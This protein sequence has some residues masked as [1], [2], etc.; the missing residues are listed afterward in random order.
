MATTMRVA[1]QIT[2]P[3]PEWTRRTG[4][5]VVGGGAAGL[6]VSARLLASGVP[7]VLISRERLITSATAWAT[8]PFDEWR[9]PPDVEAFVREGAGLADQTAAKDFLNA[10]PRV[11]DQF[12]RIAAAM[13]ST[14]DPRQAAGMT[15]YRTL[16]SL[17]RSEAAEP[18]GTLGIDTD[19]RAVDV[20]TD[21]SGHVAGLRVLGRDGV[22]GDYLAP[23]VVLASGGAGQLWTDTTTP[24]AATGDGLAMALRAGATLRD[25]EFVF[26]TPTALAVSGRMALP[27]EPLVELGSTLWRNG[28]DLVDGDQQPIWSESL[29]PHSPCELAV[30]VADARAA[31]HRDIYLD[32]RILGEDAWDSDD[33]LSTAR[34]CREHG[35]DPAH[36]PVPVRLATQTMIGG[37]AVDAHGATSVP[38]LRA[39]GEASC[40]GAMGAEGPANVS[41]LQAL[42]TGDAVGE[43]LASGQ[44]PAAG[45]PVPREPDGCTPVSTLQGIHTAADTALGMVREHER[46]R[47]AFDFLSRLPADDEL[48]ERNLTTTNLRTVGGAIAAAAIARPETRGWHRRSDHPEAS[49]SWR[50][51]I[52]I[53]CDARGLLSVTS[54][55]IGE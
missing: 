53:S 6:S 49:D 35:V 54:Q 50:R 28:A 33:Y 22:V 13:P 8:S 17:V 27:G 38:G 21:E 37:I 39:A 29:P 7:S 40:T 18:S 5:V 25:L 16:S 9:T 14:P 44:L 23:V 41:L 31:K 19:R 55:P 3:E 45:E 34:A 36:V 52:S 11:L 24:R 20:L 46:L 48:D 42:V 4:V 12:D 15:V 32:T 43:A 1:R 51:T 26:F 30:A 2:T 47:S 10:V